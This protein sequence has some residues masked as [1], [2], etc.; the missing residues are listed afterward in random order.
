MEQALLALTHDDGA[1]EDK[2]IDL[3]DDQEESP[4]ADALSAL[5]GG[6]NST[7]AVSNI[8]GLQ[9]RFNAAVALARMGSKDA[10]L[11]ILKD[12][13]DE[14]YLRQNLVLRP[15]KGG[16]D[17]PNEEVVGQSLMNA[18][19]AVA[20]LHRQRPDMDLASLTPAVDALSGSGNPDVRTEAEKTKLAL[21]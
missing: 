12:M 14:N 13:L 3:S 4:T 17:R 16:A 21:K 6:G 8:P 1:G 11:D 7:T 2:L 20:E 9:I 18:L 19:K 15:R 5:T 10:R